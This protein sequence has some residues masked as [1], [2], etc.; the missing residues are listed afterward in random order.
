MPLR[1]VAPAAFLEATPEVTSPTSLADRIQRHQAEARRLAKE[2]VESLG[3]TLLEI[4]RIAVQIAE[5]GEAYPA[6]VRDIARR[7][8][9]ESSARALLLEAIMARV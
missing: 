6:G 4:G 5:G 1:V 9:E 8:S 2:H 3:S 7:L